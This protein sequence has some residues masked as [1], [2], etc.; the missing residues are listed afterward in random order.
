MW[1]ACARNQP[2]S[3]KSAAE[4]SAQLSA[5]STAW[6]ASRVEEDA[7]PKFAEPTCNSL[8]GGEQTRST[9]A[10]SDGE[11]FIRTFRHLWCIREKK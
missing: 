9:M 11:I 8:C 2:N 4:K 5:C 1:G 10:F 3:S 7:S 6:L